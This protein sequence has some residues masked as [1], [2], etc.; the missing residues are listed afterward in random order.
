MLKKGYLASTNLYACTAHTDEIIN[1][2]LESLESVFELIKN[3]ENGK[4]VFS[5]LN[6][7]ICHSGFKRLN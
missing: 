2:Y 1:K 5:L 4:D 6:G 3:C 7:P